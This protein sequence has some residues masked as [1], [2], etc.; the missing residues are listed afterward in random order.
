MVAFEWTMVGGGALEKRVDFACTLEEEPIGVI[1]TLNV[2]NKKVRNQIFPEM[3]K[4]G[5][6]KSLM[7]VCE[8]PL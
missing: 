3:T 8:L 6:V 5:G 1:G 4:T 2:G 7:H